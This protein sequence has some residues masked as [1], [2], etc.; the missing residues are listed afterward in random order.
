VSI[1]TVTVCDYDYAAK[2]TLAQGYDGAAQTI[3]SE[4]DSTVDQAN[5]HNITQSQA[6]DEL[7]GIIAGANKLYAN[8]YQGYVSQRQQGGCSVT[9]SPPPTL[10][11]CTYDG[12]YDDV[13]NCI[14]TVTMPPSPLAGS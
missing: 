2:S 10:S 7:N 11:S 9:V 12:G 4:I 13:A 8:D 6:I 14:A 5:K 1:P 3:D